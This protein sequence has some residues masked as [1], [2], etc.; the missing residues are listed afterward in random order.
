MMKFIISLIIIMTLS[1]GCKNTEQRP[2]ENPP[3]ET[4][5][6]PAEV[7][8]LDTS[9]KDS[10]QSSKPDADEVKAPVNT[11][12]VTDTLNTSNEDHILEYTAISRGS[13]YKIVISSEHISVQRGHES[14]AIIKKCS[15]ENWSKLMQALNAIDLNEISDLKA[16]TEKRLFDGA[17][18]AQLK[19]SAD[20]VVYET[21]SFDHGVPPKA[22]ENLVKEILSIAENIE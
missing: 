14:K 16:P 7:D 2:S 20:K 13:Y 12:K 15:A 21:Q 8:T 4:E 9:V 6:L 11:S 17:A 10:L 3:A 19:I 22:I 18:G 5:A 1:E